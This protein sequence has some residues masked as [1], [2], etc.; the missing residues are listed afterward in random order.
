MRFAGDVAFLW[1]K[2]CMMLLAYMYTCFEQVNISGKLFGVLLLT[3]RE[4]VQ[5][6]DLQNAIADQKH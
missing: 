1:L 4:V 6:L 5:F 2:L 3:W